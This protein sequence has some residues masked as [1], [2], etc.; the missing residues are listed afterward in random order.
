[1]LLQKVGS[2]RV[3]H[4]IGNSIDIAL[5]T[6]N[7]YNMHLYTVYSIHDYI[8]SFVNFHF[9]EQDCRQTSVLTQK[10]SYMQTRGIL[11]NHN[12]SDP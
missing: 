12:Q 10:N 4:I 9:W 2:V 3:N 5:P 1:M 11:R 8:R 6:P 7:L